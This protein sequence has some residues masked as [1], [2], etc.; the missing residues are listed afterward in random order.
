MFEIKEVIIILNCGIEDKEGIGM[1]CFS[2]SY[3]CFITLVSVIVLT[4]VIF[5][6]EFKNYRKST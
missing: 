1:I 3:L 5:E 2:F 6:E 4:L